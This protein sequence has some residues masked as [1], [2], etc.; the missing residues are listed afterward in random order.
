MKRKFSKFTG[1]LAVGCAAALTL[2]GCGTGSNAGSSN[3]GSS[4]STSASGAVKI[5]LSFGDLN[6]ERWPHDEK[7]I[8]SYIKAHD[9]NA[10]VLVQDANGSSSTQVSQCEN[11]I[12]EGVKVLIINA[13]NG[14]ALVQVLN[15]AKRAGIPVI[16]YDRMIE[17]GPVSLY[18]SY[19]NEKVGEL[20][21]QYLTQ[22]APKGN[23]VLLE[24]DPTD[25]NAT[26]FYNGQM[27]VLNPY[28]KNGSIKVVYK[29]WTN[30]YDTNTAESEMEDA[31]TKTQN[32]VTAVL[33]ANDSIALGAIQA[34]KQQHL[35]GKVPT[36]G[37]DADLA[38]CQDIVEG[39]QTMTVYKPINT[40][41]DDAAQAALDLA[42]GK[43]PKTTGTT[44]NGFTKVPSILLS[45]VAVTKSNMMDE[46]VKSGFHTEAQVYANVP[47]SQWPK[48]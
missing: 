30:N 29:Q 6:L 14:S 24:G 7:D 34:L 1:V 10:Q 48:N 28:I 36:T 45:P 13:Q 17:N 33:D 15:D 18:V 4:N 41:A 21:A 39:L 35:A 32:N 38:N 44:D 43:T 9:P 46:I 26:Q 42:A 23:Y 12:S 16:A 31:L 27:K 2:A 25:P 22:V 47:K 19:D 40:E 8:T 5:G 37:Q 20:Q 3:A 11:L